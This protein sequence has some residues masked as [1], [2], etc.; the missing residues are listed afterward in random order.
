MSG[1]SPGRTTAWATV[2][3]AKRLRNPYGRSQMRFGGRLVRS[4]RLRSFRLTQQILCGEV[5]IRVTMPCAHQNGVLWSG[6]P[7]VRLSADSGAI[8]DVAGGR[9][10]AMGGHLAALK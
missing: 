1:A 5:Q 6:T 7:D 10:R 2:W 9:R 3:L 8:A 4:E